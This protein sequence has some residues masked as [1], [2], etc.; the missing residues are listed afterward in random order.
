M[1]ILRNAIYIIII[2]IIYYYYSYASSSTQL[3][4]SNLKTEILNVFFFLKEIT[5]IDQRDIKLIESDNK[6][7]YN[8]TQ[9]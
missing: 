7:I 6:D 1:Y 3:Y 5:F 9:E 8:A 2:I 4:A